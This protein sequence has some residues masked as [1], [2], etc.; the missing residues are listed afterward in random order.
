MMLPRLLAISNR[1]LQ[2]G[3]DL[4]DWLETMAEFEI[5]AVLIREKDLD[6][7]SLWRLV[8]EARRRLPAA[9]R[10]LVSSRPDVALAAGADGV[11][12]PAGGLPITALRKTWGGRLLYGRSTH[13]LEE[14]ESALREGADFV[15]LGP[16]FSP[17]SKP[18]ERRA[19]GLSAL[20]RATRLGLPIFAL[21]GISS[22][23][24]AEVFQAGAHGVA[25]IHAFRHRAA[26]AA[27]LTAT[28]R[29]LATI[30][31]TETE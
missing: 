15:A 22:A 5:P 10:L 6:D 1:R 26:A 2:P 16:I 29:A 18:D 24:V 11:H 19:M 20:S 17:L 31:A 3:M 12:L 14:I 28:Q 30:G 4:I 13:A 23:E 21:G 25:G 7:R 27:M 8:V 9:T